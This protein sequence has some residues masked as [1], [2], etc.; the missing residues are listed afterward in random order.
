MWLP[1]KKEYHTEPLHR[2]IENIY[3]LYPHP[4]QHTPSPPP[5]PAR[6]ASTDAFTEVANHR[7][8]A[9]LVSCSLQV[10]AVLTVSYKRERSL[11]N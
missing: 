2:Q 11:N 10:K 6:P 8:T 5:P 3:P 9:N 7:A 1:L 4:S